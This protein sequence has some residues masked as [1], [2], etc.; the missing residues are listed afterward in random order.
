MFNPGPNFGVKVAQWKEFGLVTLNF[1]VERNSR[2][3]DQC[4][5]SV[6]ASGPEHRSPNQAATIGSC[7][8]LGE[9]K[10]RTTVERK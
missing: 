9:T 4:T 10:A 1:V 8:S 3:K 7:L 5:L 2:W 6:L